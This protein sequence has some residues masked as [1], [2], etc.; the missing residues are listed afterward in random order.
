MEALVAEGQ[1]SVVCDIKTTE[2]ADEIA[3]G[4]LSAG[5][6]RL[7][8]FSRIN[9]PYLGA[10]GALDTVNFGARNTLP[11]WAK[12][13]TL[14]THNPH[15]TLMRT[16]VEE[17]QKIG[18]FIA[19]KL[20]KMLGSFVFLLPEGGLSHIDRSGGPFENKDANEAL[21]TSI[22]TCVEQ[23]SHRRVLRVPH[24]INSPEF[25]RAALRAF[26]QIEVKPE[27]RELRYGRK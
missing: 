6:Q 24:H 2:I 23:S 1:V 10:A 4:I 17:C 8:V 25:A 9:V 14:F 5:S 22:E 18:T 16:N 7:D 12:D 13:R 3:G 15:V 21:F 27:E 20:N 11:S 26:R 19:E